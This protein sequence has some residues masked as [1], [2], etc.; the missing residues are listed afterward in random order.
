MTTPRV[1]NSSNKTVTAGE[2]SA[3]LGTITNHSRFS[4]NS[5]VLM[6]Q[7]SKFDGIVAP[8]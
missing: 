3:S 8:I 4:R 7:D 6:R 5:F 2:W 1:L